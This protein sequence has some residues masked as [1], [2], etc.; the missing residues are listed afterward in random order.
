[1]SLSAPS[2]GKAFLPPASAKASYAAGELRARHL[3]LHPPRL[4]EVTFHA[5]RVK[6]AACRRRRLQHCAYHVET[7]LK[8]T[9]TGGTVGSSPASTHTCLCRSSRSQSFDFI[10]CEWADGTIY[11]AVGLCVRVASFMGC[12]WPVSSRMPPLPGSLDRQGHFPV[13][14]PPAVVLTPVWPAIPPSQCCGTVDLPKA[15]PD[16]Q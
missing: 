13:R 3:H 12:C 14:G 7:H 15:G 11:E 2:G 1:M 5:G 6:C 8:H 10:R 9:G 4:G 16:A